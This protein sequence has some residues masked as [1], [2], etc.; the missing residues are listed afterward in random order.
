M[1]NDAYTTVPDCQ[2]CAAQGTRTCH[3][4]KLLLF[5]AALPLKFLPMDI[6]AALSKTRSGNQPVIVWTDRYAKLT[7][8]IPYTTG[9]SMSAVTNFLLKIGPFCTVNRRTY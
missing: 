3:Q 7:R 6:L 4:K 8:A 2:Y 1:A 5:A 9:T